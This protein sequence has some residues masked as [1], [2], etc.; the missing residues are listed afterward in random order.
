M[1]NW[2]MRFLVILIFSFINN[3]YASSCQYAAHFKPK[4]SALSA[5]TITV[6]H[7]LPVGA[8]IH[9]LTLGDIDEQPI[10]VDCAAPTPAYWGNSHFPLQ[11][12]FQY[13]VYKTNIRGVGIRFIAQSQAFSQTRLPLTHN[14]PYSCYSREGSFSYCGNAFRGIRIQFIKTAQKTG[15]GPLATHQLIEAS[16]GQLP[17]Q[18]YR[19]LNTQILT[20]SCELQEK[21]KRVKMN[22]VK[23]SQFTGVGSQSTAVPFYLTLNCSGETSVGVLLNGRLAEN[24]DGSIIALDKRPDSAHGIGLRI[25]FQEKALFLNQIFHLGTS[26]MQSSYAV[27]F[28]AQYVQTQPLVRAG[29]ANATVTMQIV[30]P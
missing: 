27:Y 22:K 8:V 14:E 2:L 24:S 19:L 12:K 4:H 21:N 9:E 11:T 3:T 30:Y 15:S 29:K 10:M 20:P 1:M 6:A 5:G 16:V 23:Q 28:D 18:S 13:P 25:R 26:F 7:R 17:V